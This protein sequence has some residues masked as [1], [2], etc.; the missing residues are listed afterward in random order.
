MWEM[1]MCE[2]DLVRYHVV[3][4]ILPSIKMNII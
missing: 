2:D 4:H 3:D 1:L